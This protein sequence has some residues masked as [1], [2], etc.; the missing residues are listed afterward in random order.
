VAASWRRSSGPGDLGDGGGLGGEDELVRPSGAAEAA[1]HREAAGDVGGVAVE[2]AAGVDEEQLAVLHLAVVL[3]VV[4]H[5]G[6]GAAGDDGAVGRRLAAVA[7]EFVEQLGLD[8]YS[9]APGRVARMARRWAP[10]D[11]GGAAHGGD[12]GVL[13]E[14]HLVDQAAHVA[15]LGRAWQPLRAWA[16]TR[17]RASV[18]RRSQSG[19]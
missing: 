12:L 2:L 1:I 18:R 5:A 10:G 19:S 8:S 6:V 9:Q 11:V 15:D 4:Q 7:A 16:R 3:D 13:H 14:A 17:L